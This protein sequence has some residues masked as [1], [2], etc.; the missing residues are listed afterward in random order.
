[1]VILFILTAIIIVLA[2]LQAT[3]FYYSP[4]NVSRR[5]QKKWFKGEYKKHLKISREEFDDIFGQEQADSI[6]G[7]DIKMFRRDSR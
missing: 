6:D 5:R 1:M 4:Q 2:I 7:D 3:R